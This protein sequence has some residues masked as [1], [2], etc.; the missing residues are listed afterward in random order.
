MRSM[1]AAAGGAPAVNTR[2]PR[3]REPAQLFRR[4]GD[5]DEHGRRG[6][7]HGDVFLAN[8]L[9]DGARL[10][11]AQADVR[12]A[13]RGDDPDEGPAVGVE[14][15]QRPEIAVGGRHVQMHE[16]ADD[17]QLG[18]AVGDHHALGPRGRAAGV[19]DREQVALADLGARK[20]RRARPRASLRNPASRLARL[21]A[22]RNARHFG[23]ARGCDPRRRDNRSWAHTTRAPLWLM[24]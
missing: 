20:V 9:E 19:V 16:R 21:P 22:R 8:Q 17:I 12:A 2:T 5:A 6:A 18:V 23:T 3:R 11:F 15:R 7:E 4:V 13:H 10:D 14:H 1:V 24:M